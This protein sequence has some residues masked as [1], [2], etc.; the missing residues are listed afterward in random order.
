MSNKK[1][2]QE[3]AEKVYKNAGFILNQE[4]LGGKYKHDCIC[5]SNGHVIKKSLNSAQ[6]GQT[7]GT[8]FGNEKYTQE[9]A[10]K[11]YFEYG[12]ILIE[13]YV[14]SITPHKC[15]CVRSGHKV[16]KR[17][18]SVQFNHICNKCYGN[19]KHTQ[20]EAEALYL[21]KGF[22]L[23]EEYLG[24]HNRHK[25]KCKAIGHFTKRSLASVK[26]KNAICIKCRNHKNEICRKIARNLRNRFRHGLKSAFKF[27]KCSAVSD[28]GCTWEEFWIY[29]EK[30]FLP[31]MTWENHGKLWHIDHIKPLASFDLESRTE[32]LRAIHYTNLQPLWASDNIR[33]GSNY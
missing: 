33:K 9:N 27:K 1:Y 29:F 28:M 24:C 15:I 10:E 4:Y 21:E 2:T 5:I 11:L 12:F 8:C 18:D 16:T 19:K 3:E 13:T 25:V 17:L 6:Q 22:E 26:K 32:Q 30:L 20:E 7:C 14:N 23:C 31:G